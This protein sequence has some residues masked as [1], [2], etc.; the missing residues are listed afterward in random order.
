MMIGAI[1]LIH[2]KSQARYDTSW[3]YEVIYLNARI[4]LCYMFPLCRY[5]V[6]QPGGHT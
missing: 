5:S 1:E 2:A 6:L 3:I 4:E